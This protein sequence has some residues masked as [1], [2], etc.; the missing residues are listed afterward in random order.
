MRHDYQHPNVR[1][2]RGFVYT[3]AANDSSPHQY[4]CFSVSRYHPVAAVIPHG[5][6]SRDY[7]GDNPEVKGSVPGAGPPTLQAGS[8]GATLLPLRR[9]L[10]TSCHLKVA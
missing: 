10:F 6:R 9:P 5:C 8:P 1:M 2:T 4:S 7:H 3:D